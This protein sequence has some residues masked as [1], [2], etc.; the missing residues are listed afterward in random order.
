MKTL[1]RYVLVEL[2]GEESW[3]VRIGSGDYA[4]VVYKYI[5]VRVIEPDTDDGYATLKYNY[6]VLFHAELPESKFAKNNAFETMIGDIL[7]ELI[8]SFEEKQDD[9][10]Q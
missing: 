3:C 2:D 9:H 4:N 7:Y 6:E 10:Q 8:M 5:H 1:P